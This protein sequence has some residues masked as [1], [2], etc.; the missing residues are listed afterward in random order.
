MSALHAPKKISRRQ[1]LRQDAVVSATTHAFDLFDQNRTASIIGFAALFIAILGFV[2]FKFY[3]DGQSVEAADLLGGIVMTYEAGLYEEALDGTVDAP[4]LLEIASRYGNTPDG[5]LATFYAADALF[6]LDR[7]D[8]AL[9]YFE[10]YDKGKNYIGA[11]AI[12]GEAAV[13]EDRGDAER[14]ADLYRR[15]ALIYES[16]LTSPEYLLASARNYETAGEYAA[17]REM[18]E[19]IRDRFPDSS[20][21]GGLELYLARLDGIES[22]P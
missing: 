3:Q 18:Y 9:Q 15:A 12:A 4:G 13:H 20:P 14:A 17:A 19:T 11:S 22:R 16:N 8:E 2:G 21:A 5:N 7:K 6:R 1:E 10:A